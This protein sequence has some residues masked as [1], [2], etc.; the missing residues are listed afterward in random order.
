LQ[1]GNK[2][3]EVLHDLV[4]FHEAVRIVALVGPAGQGALPVGGDEA[5]AVPALGAPAM[6]EA[7]LFQH[8]VVYA[9]LLEIIAGGKAGLA[10]ANDNNAVMLRQGRVDGGV[11]GVAP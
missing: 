6:G 4:F 8:Q 7:V 9:L 10:T 5:E 1:R 2:A 3:V 11:H